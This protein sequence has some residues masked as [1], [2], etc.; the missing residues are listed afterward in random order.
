MDR[1]GD[2]T[3]ERAFIGQMFE[4]DAKNYHVWSYRQW[5]VRRFDLWDSEMHDIEA[6]LTRDIRNNSAWNHRWFIVVGRGG[7]APVDG[8]IIR[9]EIEYAQSAILQAPQNQSPWNYLRGMLRKGQ[10]A[11]STTLDFVTP[12]ANITNANP[13]ANPDT[14]TNTHPAVRSSH[15]LDLLADIY[16]AQPARRHDAIKA[17]DLLAQIYDPIRANY[18]RYRKTCLPPLENSSAGADA[19]AG[20]GASPT[21]LSAA[22]VVAAT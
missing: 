17:L 16:A 14:N 6:L 9:R 8:D 19:G 1:L 20:A 18:W 10:I 5:L 13:D 4:M 21:P 2:W 7:G 22:V 12:L 11:L 3:G 15:A